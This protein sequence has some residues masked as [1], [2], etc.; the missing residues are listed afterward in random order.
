M[1]P[2]HQCIIYRVTLAHIFKT[3]VKTT[4]LV[5]R[6]Y[7]EFCE[8]SCWLPKATAEPFGIFVWRQLGLMGVVRR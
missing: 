4:Y 6:N 7:Q 1:Y 3:K 8:A 2:Y 5:A